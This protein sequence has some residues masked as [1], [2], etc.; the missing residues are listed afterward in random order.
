[1]AAGICEVCET[2]RAEVHRNRKTNREVCRSCHREHYQVRDNCS[3]CGKN[4]IVA[5]RM[6]DDKAVCMNCYGY[7]GD[8]KE[9]FR[10]KKLCSRCGKM[11]TAESYDESKLPVCPSCYKKELR[12]KG[13]CC[14][15]Q[16]EAHI[17]RYDPVTNGPICQ[18][19][20]WKTYQRR[21]RVAACSACGKEKK[22]FIVSRNLCAACY[23]RWENKTHNI[24]G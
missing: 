12:L 1:M 21:V 19:C 2:F 22:I 8:K 14:K 20:Y 5:L 15:C 16:Q 3:V 10:P 17:V 9:I 6:P 24:P 11:K 18:T 23:L 7:S 13:I 4:S